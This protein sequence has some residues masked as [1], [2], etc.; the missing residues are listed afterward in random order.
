MMALDSDLAAARA[1]IDAGLQDLAKAERFTRL[2]R[3]L[4]TVVIGIGLLVS[5][6]ALLFTDEKPD[7]PEPGLAAAGTRSL[8]QQVTQQHRQIEQLRQQIDRLSKQPVPPASGQQPLPDVAA[9]TKRMEAIEGEQRRLG[10]LI[11]DTPEKA[12]AI[13]LM[14]RN[15][16]EVRASQTVVADALRRDIDRIYDLNKWLFGGLA[17]S[18]IAL[19]V[20]EFLGRRERP[21]RKDAAE[22]QADR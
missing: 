12:L 8:S 15:I 19:V 2:A 20:R 22:P 6:S 18:V 10:A 21:S 3:N 7:L 5:M 16:D 13:P 14:R 4:T 17:V 1:R 9:L 11:M